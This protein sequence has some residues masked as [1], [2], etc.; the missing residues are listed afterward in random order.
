MTGDTYWDPLCFVLC[1]QPM[2]AQVTTLE[3]EVQPTWAGLVEPLERISDRNQRAWGVVSHLKGVKVGVAPQL[4][5]VK[6][7]C[8][9]VHAWCTSRWV[10]LQL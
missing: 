1:I 5:G 8:K 7:S 2:L 6:V 9:G 10:G 3:A 4:Q